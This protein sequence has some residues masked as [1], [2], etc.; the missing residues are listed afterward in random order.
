[1]LA[2]LLLALLMWVAVQFLGT[3]MVVTLVV[4]IVGVLAFGFCRAGAAA[5]RRSVEAVGASAWRLAPAGRAAIVAVPGPV[6]RATRTGP[7]AYQGS[8]SYYMD[9][10]Q[11]DAGFRLDADRGSGRAA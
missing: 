8:P 4:M 5:R 7:G 10:S 1:M 9:P 3:L 2:V 11:R 6:R